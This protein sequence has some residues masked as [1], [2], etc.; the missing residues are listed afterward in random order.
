MA[1]IIHFFIFLLIKEKYMNYLKTLIV[2]ICLLTIGCTPQRIIHNNKIF[3]YGKYINQS[4]TLGKYIYIIYD[5]ENEFYN[6]Y[7]FTLKTS[8]EFNPGDTL[9]IINKTSKIK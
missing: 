2:G 4:D 8:D 6:K 7:L 5:K 9:W 3:V 1:N